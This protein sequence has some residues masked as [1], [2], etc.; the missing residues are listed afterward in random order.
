MAHIN[1]SED[2]T[3][4]C[5]V[6]SSDCRLVIHR[7]LHI[8]EFLKYSHPGVAN[9]FGSQ[10]DYFYAK[11]EEDGVVMLKL[12]QEKYQRMIGL[13]FGDLIKSQIKRK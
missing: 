9:K 3:C 10:G 13:N 7:D 11:D 4:S 8:S 5:G 6:Y 1:Y 12:M 2:G